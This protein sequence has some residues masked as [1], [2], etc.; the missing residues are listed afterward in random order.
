MMNTAS[1]AAWPPGASA[2]QAAAALALPGAAD[3]NNSRGIGTFGRIGRIPGRRWNL[4]IEGR[5]TTGGQD[6][7]SCSECNC[8]LFATTLVWLHPKP[9]GARRMLVPSSKTE[10]ATAAAVSGGWRHARRRPSLQEAFG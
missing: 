3:C 10:P 5:R 7:C 6:V 4:E 9:C 2:A 1:E 8:K